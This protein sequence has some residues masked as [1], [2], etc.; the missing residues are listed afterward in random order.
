VVIQ[1]VGANAVR[2]ADAVGT[3]WLKRHA[4]T[5]NG[6]TVLKVDGEKRKLPRADLAQ[7]KA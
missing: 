4:S 7:L 1:L 5:V 3:A 2:S 6:K